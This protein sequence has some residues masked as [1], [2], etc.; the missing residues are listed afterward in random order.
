MKKII[1]MVTNGIFRKKDIQSKYEPEEIVPTKKALV[2]YMKLSYSL[3]GKNP[4]AED[5]PIS[6]HIDGIR[7]WIDGWDEEMTCVIVAEKY[8]WNID[9]FEYVYQEG[10]PRRKKGSETLGVNL[11]RRILMHQNADMRWPEFFAT[12]C[13]GWL[14]GRINMVLDPLI[15]NYGHSIYLCDSREKAYQRMDEIWEL[16]KYD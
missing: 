10:R 13:M 6:D 8:G 9:G 4:V 2:I 12:E 15:F 11:I 7:D 3:E 1:R 5:A 14:K 16:K